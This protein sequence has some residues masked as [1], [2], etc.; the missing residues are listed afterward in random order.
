MA[1]NTWIFWP[2]SGLERVKVEYSQPYLGMTAAFSG[3]WFS[4]SL[5]SLS[6]SQ[7]HRWLR[8]AE[9]VEGHPV[10]T[11]LKQGHLKPVAQDHVQVAFECL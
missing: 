2:L 5:R 8:L 3:S 7:N 10:Y 1:K 9:T 6:N 4:V 11:L